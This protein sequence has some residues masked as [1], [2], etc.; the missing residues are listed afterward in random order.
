MTHACP[1][2]VRCR[3]R[4]IMPHAEQGTQRSVLPEACY[5]LSLSSLVPA[6][7]AQMAQRSWS[8]LALMSSHGLR[9]ALPL[10]CP[11]GDNPHLWKGLLEHFPFCL[12][13]RN[14]WPQSVTPQGPFS[15]WLP[16]S[17]VVG[18]F[19]LAAA[20]GQPP[21]RKPSSPPSAVAKD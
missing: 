17:N 6:C 5:L 7:W 4:P 9:L 3:K 18:M 20:P 8:L 19:L 16:P 21:A 14:Q 13:Q 1:S 15:S 12:E 10:P 11:D 2:S